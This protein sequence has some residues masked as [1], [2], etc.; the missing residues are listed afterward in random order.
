MRVLYRN[1]EGCLSVVEVSF[2]GYN[3]EDG[4]H[5]LYII[6]VDDD[7]LT[8][9]GL[10]RGICESLVRELYREGRVDL[11]IYQVMED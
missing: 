2:A 11:S 4:E 7:E 1:E 3:E 10:D 9:E 8:V 6:T 5:G